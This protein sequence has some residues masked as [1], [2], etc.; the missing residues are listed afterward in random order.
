MRT[1]D[2]GLL[3]NKTLLCLALTL[4][5]SAPVLAEE[6]A[7]EQPASQVDQLLPICQSCHGDKG[8][9]PMMPSYPVLAGQYANY[10]EHALK[11]Y[12]SGA[13]NNPI[14]KA[15]VATVSDADIKALAQYFA[16]QESPLYTFTLPTG[17]AAPAPAAK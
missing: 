16:Q 6:A 8:A 4:G 7:H 1:F 2:K 10:L 13:R 17:G 14:M 5:V 15:Q 11:D 9:K 12:R 3:V